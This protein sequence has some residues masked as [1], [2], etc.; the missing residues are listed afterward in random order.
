MAR[1]QKFGSETNFATSPNNRSIIIISQGPLTHPKTSTWYLILRELVLP[2]ISLTVKIRHRVKCGHGIQWKFYGI[3]GF[4]VV[5]L[6]IDNLHFYWI[7]TPRIVF[8]Q[9]NVHWLMIGKMLQLPKREEKPQSLLGFYDWQWRHICGSVITWF[10]SVD[11]LP[12]PPPWSAIHYR[13]EEREV[14]QHL[15]CV[16]GA[17]R[18]KFTSLSSLPIKTNRSWRLGSSTD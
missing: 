16:G 8:S 5:H 13:P 15:G 4:D 6:L 12:P 7:S 17:N 3:K 18:V 10:W 2:R 14:S 9:W 1:D 11:A